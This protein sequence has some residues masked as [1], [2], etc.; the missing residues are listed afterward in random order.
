MT[1]NRRTLLSHSAAITATVT[2]LAQQ[3]QTLEV[4]PPPPGSRATVPIC[5]LWNEGLA[6]VSPDVSRLA[7]SLWHLEPHLC[8]GQNANYRRQPPSAGF[9]V[10]YGFAPIIGRPGGLPSLVYDAD[11]S[12]GLF[13]LGPHTDYPPHQHPA[14]EQYVPLTVANWWKEDDIWRQ[15]PA[16]AL[17]HHDP[18]RSHA[19]RTDDV[20]LFAIYVWRGDVMSSSN[21]SPR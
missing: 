6:Q 17:I 21:W 11:L 10:N 20:P 16:G 13:V 8:W 12:I 14:L 19:M 9:L 1:L 3:C 5:R 7:E 4:V 2:L 15:H 18:E